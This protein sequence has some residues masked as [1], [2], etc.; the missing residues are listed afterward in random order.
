[1]KK[2]TFLF[3]ST[4]HEVL[5]SKKLKIQKFI[6]LYLSYCV[7]GRFKKKISKKNFFSLMNRK[8]HQLCKGKHYTVGLKKQSEDL[9]LRLYTGSL[10]IATFEKSDQIFVL[11]AVF[12]PNDLR[13]LNWPFLSKFFIQQKLLMASDQKI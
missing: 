12:S 8:L 7:R 6:S 11:G 1:M 10:F 5:N 2:L 3:W 13:R 4:L 9:G